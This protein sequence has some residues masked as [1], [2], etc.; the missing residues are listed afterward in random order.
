LGARFRDV[1]KRAQNLA[2]DGIDLIKKPGKEGIP[3]LKLRH[4]IGQDRDYSGEEWFRELEE[5]TDLKPCDKVLDV[6]SGTGRMS[7]PLTEYLDSNGTYDGLEIIKPFVDWCQKNITTKHPNFR[8]Q[9][10]DVLN[11]AYTPNG[12]ALA[13]D[14]RFPFENEA[15]DVVFLSSVFTH[16]FPRDLENYLKEIVRVLKKDGRCM[17]S[18]FLLNDVLPRLNFKITAEGYGAL[19]P[20]NPEE[21]IAYREDYILGLYKSNKLTVLSPI[22][23]GKGGGQDVIVAKKRL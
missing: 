19:N 1:A 23:Y 7:L 17:I 5:R 11:K 13:S 14:Y 22:Y 20:E 9:H 16:M 15:F 10:V 2:F 12:K 8:F 18:Y 3:P 4:I 6:G 21:G